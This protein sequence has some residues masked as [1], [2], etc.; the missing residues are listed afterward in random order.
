MASLDNE[1][2]KKRINELIASSKVKSFLLYDVEYTRQQELFLKF[3]TLFERYQQDP[4]NLEILLSGLKNLITNFPDK[5]LHILR[6]IGIWA[7]PP[8]YKIIN[9]LQ[10][11]KLDNII[12]YGAGCALWCSIL[13]DTLTNTKMIA[14]DLYESNENKWTNKHVGFYPV[15]TKIDLNEFKNNTMIM[16]LYPPSNGI[17][18]SSALQNF[19][20]E[21]VLFYGNRKHTGDD[22]FFKE[23]KEYWIIQKTFLPL[24]VL[25]DEHGKFNDKIMIFKR[26]IE[27]INNNTENKKEETENKIVVVEN[28]N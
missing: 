24:A 28:K 27:I 23:L 6:E 17:M 21:Y 2:L 18:A 12:D 14:Y 8:T 22:D 26:K 5:S 16:F 10:S 20:G 11:L 13:R 1:T 19:K 7:L 9:Y 15:Q 25:Q 4:L 3:V